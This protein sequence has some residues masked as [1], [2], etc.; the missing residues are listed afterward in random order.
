MARNSLAVPPARQPALPQM[1]PVP[2]HIVIQF[3]V[4]MIGISIEIFLAMVLLL[5]CWYTYLS[6]VSHIDYI[7]HTSGNW[8]PVC[9][10][11]RTKQQQNSGGHYSNRQIVNSGHGLWSI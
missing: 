11:N 7:P 2:L 3:K 6:F 5:H 1:T 4:W 8:W 9:G 10:S